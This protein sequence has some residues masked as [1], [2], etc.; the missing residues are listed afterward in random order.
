[1]EAMEFLV[2]GLKGIVPSHTQVEVVTSSPAAPRAPGA[3][4]LNIRNSPALV[5]P[6]GSTALPQS[7][8]PL[9]VKSWMMGEDSKVV[10][11]PEY[12]LNVLEPSAEPGTKPRVLKSLKIKPDETWFRAKPNAPNPTLE[13]QLP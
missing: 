8:T 2:V 4:D 12:T 13:I 6:N 5:R 3:A 9:I 11:A 1:V 7:L 10:P